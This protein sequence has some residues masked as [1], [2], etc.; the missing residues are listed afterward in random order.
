MTWR[1]EGA[2]IFF[3][4]ILASSGNAKSQAAF[5][6]HLGSYFAKNQ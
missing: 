4:G 2:A 6:A 5:G 3:S 1:R